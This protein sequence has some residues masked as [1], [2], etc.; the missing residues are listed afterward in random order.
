MPLIGIIYTPSTIEN[1]LPPFH[2]QAKWLHAPKLSYHFF[3]ALTFPDV[4]LRC[5][6]A[7]Y[8]S[9]WNQMTEIYFKFFFSGQWMR[10]TTNGP[11]VPMTCWWMKLHSIRFLV[12]CHYVKWPLPGSIKAFLSINNQDGNQTILNWIR[13]FLCVL[14]RARVCVCLS[15]FRASV[16]LR[17]F[18]VALKKNVWA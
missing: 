17:Y 7:F 5:K 2:K 9:F 8:I 6:I 11:F 4:N 1:A 14:V 3:S 15:P 10:I 16:P 13:S 18:V 12:L